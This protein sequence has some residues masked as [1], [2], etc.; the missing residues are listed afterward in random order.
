MR[1]QHSDLTASI[2]YTVVLHTVPLVPPA[3]D[4]SRARARDGSLDPDLW[5]LRLDLEAPDWRF[6]DNRVIIFFPGVGYKTY[7]P[8]KSP[9]T[10]FGKSPTTYFG[11]TSCHTIEITASRARPRLRLGPPS[12]RSL[13]PSRPPQSEARTD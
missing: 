10:Y 4:A 7:S 11:K 8:K 12:C 6:S 3:R 9:T 1:L 5:L 13:M 2:V